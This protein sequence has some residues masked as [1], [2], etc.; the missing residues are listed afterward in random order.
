[1]DAL[2]Q[3]IQASNN[4]KSLVDAMIEKLICKVYNPVDQQTALNYN[5]MI[6]MKLTVSY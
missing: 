6:T 4:L 3:L 1:M 5:L 2:A